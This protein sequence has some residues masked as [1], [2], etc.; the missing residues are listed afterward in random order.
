VN[1]KLLFIILALTSRNLFSVIKFD[2]KDRSAALALVEK[3]LPKNPVIL[4]AGA[5]DGTDTVSMSQLW[6]D[7][8]IYAFEPVP[9]IYNWL[10][11]KTS[12]CNNVRCFGIALS[13]KVGY[14]DFFLSEDPNNPG[15]SFQSGSL[16]EP[17]EHLKY[18]HIQF[19]K[20][21][22]VPTITIDCWAEIYGVDHVDMMWLDMQGMELEVL[23]ASPKILATVK[24]VCMEVEFVEA[25][26]GQGM[27]EDVKKFMEE[28]GFLE[29]AKNFDAPGKGGWGWFGDV[30]FVRQ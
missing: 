5:F 16:L 17:K 1:I 11:N 15:V 4:E 29:Y 26:A 14:Q 21:M 6:S 18:S 30:V 10:T 3:I 2:V 9:E 8:T 25:Y 13:N 27:Y 28:S 24:V 22:I 19:N 12:N 23:R 7:S 20:K